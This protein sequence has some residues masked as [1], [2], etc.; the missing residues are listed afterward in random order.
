MGLQLHYVDS[1]G[2]HLNE[3]LSTLI[4]KHIQFKLNDTF[5]IITP[6]TPCAQDIEALLLEDPKLEKVL[7]GKSI[8]TWAQFWQGILWEHP[9]QRP[10]APPAFEKKALRMALKRSGKLHYVDLPTQNQYLRELKRIHYLAKFQKLRGKPLTAPSIGDFFQKIIGEEFKFWSSE[11]AM[12]QVLDYINSSPIQSLAEIKDIYFLGFSFPD[13]DMLTMIQSLQRIYPSLN[14]YLFLPP[15]KRLIDTGGLISPLLDQLEEIAEKKTH[16]TP[17][18]HLAP[19]CWIH[20]TPFHEACFLK[21]ELLEKPDD[22]LL[23]FPPGGE[24]RNYFERMAIKAQNTFLDPGIPYIN[25]GTDPYR[26]LVKISEI[27]EE[28]PPIYLKDFLK[29]LVPPFQDLRVKLAKTGPLLALKH[30]EACFGVLQEKHQAESFQEE[31]RPVQEWVQEIQEEFRSRSFSTPRNS[32]LA[33]RLRNLESPGLRPIPRLMA[34]NLNEGTYPSHSG[35]RLLPELNEDP[36]W[37]HQKNILLQQSFFLAQKE[38]HLNCPDHDM[39]GRIQ[40]P[41]PLLAS[42][43]EQTPPQKGPPLKP[44]MESQ[45]PY[46][47]ENIQ[48]ERKRRSLEFNIDNGKLSSIHPDPHIFKQIQKRPLSASY[49]DDYVKCPWRFLARWHFKTDRLSEEGLAIEPKL[50]G[51]ITHSLLEK[52][53]Q[54]YL[55]KYFSKNSLPN[56]QAILETLEKSIQDTWDHIDQ[57]PEASLLPKRVLEDDIQRIQKQIQELVLK[58]MDN[59]KSHEKNLLPAYLEWKFGLPPL[60]KVEFSLDKKRSIPLA[61]AIDRID[62]SPEHQEFLVL[63]YKSSG[64]EDL[65]RNLR[66]GL[67]FQLFLYILAVHQALFPQANALGGLYWDLKKQKMNQGLAIKDR[68]ADYTQDRL[69]T[70]SFLSRENFSEL[71]DKTKISLQQ[72]LSKLLAGDYSLSPAKCDGSR[73][74]Y[75]EICRYEKQPQQ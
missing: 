7:I 64:S 34:A 61:G 21:E 26:L 23:L 59:W 10:L 31:L 41:T 20:R 1:I 46:F 29:E 49:L 13:S 62:Y 39:E 52:V 24:T 33:A 18:T 56:T 16:H 44:R 63:D 12:E 54:P 42:L 3:I 57:Y 36:L 55:E 53:Y 8:L 2:P 38:L 47:N 17:M 27:W 69:S 19:N 43:W 14:I 75:H 4:D 40:S 73:C 65:S 45:H 67:S 74:P 68:F 58:E 37:D 30:L 6:D 5:R 70:R 71:I 25:P 60:P 9:R 48:R 72:T 66:E 28:N 32:F 11:Q 50:K 35:R 51:K 15:P 22:T